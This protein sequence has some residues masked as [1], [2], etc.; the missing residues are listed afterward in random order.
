MA[1][2]FQQTKWHFRPFLHYLGQKVLLSVIFT[3]LLTLLSLLPVGFQPKIALAALTTNMDASLVYGQTNFIDSAKPAAS[4]TSVGYPMGLSTDG[5]SLAITDNDNRV[6]LYNSIPTSSNPSADVVI[7]QQNMTSVLTNQ[8]GSPAANTLSSPQYVLIVGSKLIIAD[9]ANNRVLIYNSIPTSNNAS[10]D[11]VVGQQNMTG[12]SC[13]QGATVSDHTLCQPENMIIVGSKLIIDDSYSFRV[14][15]YN[16]IP[17]ANNA[18]ADV[19]IGHT[20]MN[21][22]CANDCVAAGAANLGFTEGIA[23]DGTNLAISD[24]DDT[25][26]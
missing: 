12:N 15:I 3:V 22:E 2:F 9:G 24:F 5:T 16:S 23:S 21:N 7:G 10:A 14:L 18:A 25:G 20:V 1:Q 6:L 26:F 4:A 13:D 8:G 11:V 17:T 19:V